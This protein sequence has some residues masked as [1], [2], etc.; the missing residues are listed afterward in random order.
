MDSKDF[1][2][3]KDI[4]DLAING[5]FLIVGLGGFSSQQMGKRHYFH[6][7]HYVLSVLTP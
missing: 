6:T 4:F 7:L 5:V 2:L 3:I 1:N